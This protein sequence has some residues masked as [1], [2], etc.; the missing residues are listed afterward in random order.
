MS[1]FSF[2]SLNQ[3]GSLQCPTCK[4]IYGEKT[5]T[6]PPGKMEYHVIPHCLPGY[7][8]SKSIRIV[9]DIPAGIQVRS[10]L[11]CKSAVMDGPVSRSSASSFSLAYLLQLDSAG[12]WGLRHWSNIHKAKKRGIKDKLLTYSEKL[13]Y[14]LTSEIVDSVI[15]NCRFF[16]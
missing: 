5:G 16:Y 13:D 12:G 15:M 4:T 7:P 3:D 2:V 8:D 10:K 11:G 1:M 9:Y 6:Q 14:P